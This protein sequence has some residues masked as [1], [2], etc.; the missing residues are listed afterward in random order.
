MVSSGRRPKPHSVPTPK[1]D[2]KPLRCRSPA[3]C[4]F[5]PI[6]K[7][8]ES[9]IKFGAGLKLEIAQWRKI[10]IVVAIARHRHMQPSDRTVNRS[11]E[12]VIHINH[13]AY[14]GRLPNMLV[15]RISDLSIDSCCHVAGESRSMNNDSNNPS[16]C[17]VSDKPDPGAFSTVLRAPGR[18]R[19][20]RT[21]TSRRRS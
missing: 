2:T 20:D 19:T 17:Q 10:R 1:F 15:A 16:V 8:D 9:K 12:A 7:M 14:I 18:R 3:L 21:S 5:D 11:C 13:A 6:G 4:T